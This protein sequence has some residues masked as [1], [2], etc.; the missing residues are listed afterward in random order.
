MV[1]AMLVIVA[2]LVAVASGWRAN[3]DLSVEQSGMLQVNSNPTGAT[4]Y[5][6][7]RRLLLGTNTSEMLTEGKHWVELSRDGYDSWSKEVA[8]K[9]GWLLRL[10]EPRL[11]KQD[12]E[13]ETVSTLTDV[14]LVSAAP[15]RETM[16]IGG[17]STEWQWLAVRG[18]T[19]QA[20]KVNLAGVLT[21]KEGKLEGNLKRL[22]WNGNGDRVLLEW[23]GTDAAEWVMVDLRNE[24]NSVNLTKRTKAKIADA[25]FE[26][27]GGDRVMFLEGGILKTVTMG[28][29]EVKTTELANV[30]RFDVQNEQVIYVTTADKQG[31][32]VVGMYRD[33]DKGGVEVQKVADAQAN[34]YVALGTY[35][36]EKNLFYTIGNQL[37][38]YRG[39]DYPGYEGNMETMEQV[40]NQEIDLA[41]NEDLVVSWTGQL[42]VARNG[43]K[44]VVFD[45]ET[46]ACASFE[47][48]EKVTRWLDD[49]ELVSVQDG[50]LMERDF[51][52]TNVRTLVKSGVASGF[53]A[54]VTSN[55][56][57]LYYVTQGEKG[58]ELRRESLR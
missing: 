13:A 26:N 22:Q 11:F 15:N 14:N 8:I 6:D 53:D 2:I 46:A 3:G 30:A 47:Y 7:G 55:N 29:L 57:W 39:Q 43:E 21:A 48:G 18:G 56:R 51:D 16:L 32:R 20:T 58:L 45:A 42:V 28:D 4:V 1:A 34:V 41:P 36:G 40:L 5:I 50:V 25:Q 35:Y 54:M 38:V 9:P 27:G 19:T 12:R 23:Q 10:Q 37:Y 33:G 24:K 44:V 52:N 31:E 17:V 49:Y